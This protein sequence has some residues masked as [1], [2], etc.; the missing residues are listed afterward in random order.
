MARQK[1][2]H[3]ERQQSDP[4]VA[5]IERV[6]KVER[7][8]VAELERSAGEARQ[9][10]DEARTRGS[11]IARRTDARIS[12]IHAAYLQKVQQK[13]KQQQQLAEADPG[14]DK[15]GSDREPEALAEAVRRVAIKLTGGT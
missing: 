6:L 12:K 14:G 2:G 3:P 5:A 1:A 7:D 8:G 13:Q 10:L 15:S 9:L 11:N 4:V